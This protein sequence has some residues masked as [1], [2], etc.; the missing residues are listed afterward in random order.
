MRLHL[1]FS[2][3]TNYA[4]S[5][6]LRDPQV[7]RILI[8]AIAGHAYFLTQ[9]SSGILFEKLRKKL[10]LSSVIATN[11]PHIFRILKSIKTGNDEIPIEVPVDKDTINYFIGC[12]AFDLKKLNEFLK[13]NPNNVNV[14]MWRG[15]FDI[16]LSGKE[17]E[18]LPILVEMLSLANDYI[19]KGEK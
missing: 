9:G 19:G 14:Y 4:D 11:R 5:L 18:L 16:T 6:D 17:Q 10:G 3:T 7:A 13:K 15:F 1:V 8:P 2:A 12:G